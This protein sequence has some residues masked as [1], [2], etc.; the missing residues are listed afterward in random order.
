M[1]EFFSASVRSANPQRA[2]LECL[3]TALGVGHAG[4]DLLIINAAIGHRLQDLVAHARTQCP[5]ARVVATS[6]AGVVGREG[7]SESMKDVALMAVRGREFAVGHVDGVHGHNAREKAIELATQLRR[8]SADINMAYLI[9]PGIDIANDSMIQ[10]FKAVLGPQVTLFGATSADNMRALTCL[11]AVDSQVFQH[12]AFAVGLYDPGLQVHTRATHGFVAVGQP[13]TV[14]SAQ[15]H[16]IL[17]LDGKPAWPEYLSRLG[18][19]ATATIADS[20]PIGALAERLPPD[21]ACEYG[22]E[23]I[24]R[25]VTRHDADGAMHYPTTCRQGTQLWLTVR[26]EERIFKDLDRLLAALQV[27]AQGRKPV[28]VF[29][30][31]CGARGRLLFNRVMKE[32]LIQRLQHPFSTDGVPPPWLGMYGFGEYARLGADNEYHNYTTAVAALYRS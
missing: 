17:A 10:G 31:D 4:C 18:L 14:T 9:A 6:C 11:Q 22:N 8:A 27:Q 12:A 3:E 32:E 25:A 5:G 20:A 29:Q 21:L 24:L 26:D 1:L 23:H 15:G 13:L 30:A 16:R 19:P 2:I 28:A 7:V